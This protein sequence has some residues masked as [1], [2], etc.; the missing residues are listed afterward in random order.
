MQYL[1]KLVHIFHKNNSNKPTAIFFL[2]NTAL[3]I[4]WLLIVLLAKSAKQK[5]DQQTTSTWNK[6][7]KI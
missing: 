1:Q 6:K 7:A 3:P 2:V 4:A 5:H